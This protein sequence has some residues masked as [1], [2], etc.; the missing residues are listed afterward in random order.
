MEIGRSVL[1]LHQIRRSANIFLQ[2]RIHNYIQKGVRKVNVNT[3]VTGNL[4]Q[5]VKKATCLMT[6]SSTIPAVSHLRIVRRTKKFG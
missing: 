1:F 5:I 2:I 6:R 3:I 4:A